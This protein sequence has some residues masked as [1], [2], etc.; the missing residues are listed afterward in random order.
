MR[1]VDW[2]DLRFF[3]AVS[4]RGAISGRRILERQ[5]F[6][7]AAPPNK[8]G[9]KSWRSI[10]RSLAGRLSDNRAGRGAAHSIA[11]SKR[12]DRNR[13]NELE[14]AESRTFR[15]HPHHDTDTLMHGL[16][17]PYVAEFHAL[18]PATQME[19][20]INNTFSDDFARRDLFYISSA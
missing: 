6:D 12:A 7:C 14:R 10:V 15:C 18:S 3:L 13:P 17:M 9:K 19:I 1:D 8:P 11:W 5:P 4:E 20:V 16:L 2:D